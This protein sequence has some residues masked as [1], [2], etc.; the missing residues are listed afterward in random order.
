[1]KYKMKKYRIKMRLKMSQRKKKHGQFSHNLVFFIFDVNL[2]C[3]LQM[4]KSAFIMKRHI[5]MAKNWKNHELTKN[6]NNLTNFY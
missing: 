6:K 4:I 1:M 5:L 3:L 2:E